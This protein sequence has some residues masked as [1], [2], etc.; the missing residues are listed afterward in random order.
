MAT[1]E[2]NG[3][4]IDIKADDVVKCKAIGAGFDGIELKS[5]GDEFRLSGKFFQSSCP[6]WVEILEVFA[7]EKKLVEI[8]VETT[9]KT[10]KGRA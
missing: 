4:K 1:Y 3:E 6:S 10:A 5:E 8:A 7:T 2:V 9:K